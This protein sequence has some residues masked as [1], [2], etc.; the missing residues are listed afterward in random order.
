MQATAKVNKSS[1]SAARGSVHGTENN[2]TNLCW[3]NTLFEKKPE[4]ELMKKPEDEL[5]KKDDEYEIKLM[6]ELM[7]E[8]QKKEDELTKEYEMKLKKK[9]DELK[10]HEDELK[11]EHEMKLRKQSKE[12]AR[13]LK[14]QKD[15]LT[16]ETLWKL[17]NQFNDYQRELQNQAND[18]EMK[19]KATE[20]DYEM[21][22]K[23]Q[24]N[25]GQVIKPRICHFGETCKNLAT[26][27]CEYLHP[28]GQVY[29]GQKQRMDQ[30]DQ[31]QPIDAGVI[32]EQALRF[33]VHDDH[34]IALMVA[35]EYE[36]MN[37]EEQL[38]MKQRM[39][40]KLKMNEW[41]CLTCTFLNP[42]DKINCDVCGAHRS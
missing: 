24:G 13:R 23:R 18:Y 22:L 7:R 36:R 39:D 28:E 15:E 5:M 34:R 19:L 31:V 37:K 30:E 40:H 35:G 14:R 29:K 21:K 33:R 8:L 2:A 10:K 20:D 38:Q 17:K 25:K 27:S 9:E 1:E 26:N 12:Y 32:Q 11:N 16:K 4:D 41:Q 3:G 42:L 6:R